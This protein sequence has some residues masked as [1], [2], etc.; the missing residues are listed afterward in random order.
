[1]AKLLVVDD[2][3]S[4]CWGLTRLGE[5]NGHK[6]T[7]VSSAE[8]ALET[9]E[10][11]KPDVV[12]LDVRLPG[13][14]GLTAIGKLRQHIGQ[15]PII[16][17][18]AYG[19]LKT[20][21]E[22]VRNGAFEYIIKP[23]DLQTDRSADSSGIPPHCKKSSNSSHWQLPRTPESSFAARVEPARNSRL[24]QFTNTAIVTRVPSWQ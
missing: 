23:F 11:F 1:M 24:E 4:I 2:E 18:T 12:I 9:V 16:V 15:T 14:D 7:T 21:V 10:S 13:M 6:V 20:A 8:Q 19:D 3:Q 5:S 17:I 22:A